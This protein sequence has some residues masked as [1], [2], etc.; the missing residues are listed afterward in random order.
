MSAEKL[1]DGRAGLPAAA[2]QT[3]PF[4]PRSV[5]PYDLL[6]TNPDTTFIGVSNRQGLS[7]A[8]LDFL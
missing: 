3:E 2:P 8:G 4:K 5:F 1:I 6:E 7:I